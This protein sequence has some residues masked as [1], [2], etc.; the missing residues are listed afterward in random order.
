MAR[1][2]GVV[3]LLTEAEFREIEPSAPASVVKHTRIMGSRHAL[4]AETWLSCGASSRV[5]LPHHEP[6][7]RRRP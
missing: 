2:A 1:D 4:D 6:T 5:R 7:G 3:V